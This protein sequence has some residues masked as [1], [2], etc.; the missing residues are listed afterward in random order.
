MT[1]SD[2]NYLRAV[3]TIYFPVQS[4]NPLQSEITRK[5]ES[6]VR[7]EF[8]S[9]AVLALVCRSALSGHTESSSAVERYIELG[10]RLWLNYNT[11][12]MF[13]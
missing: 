7:F 11:V 10:G 12:Q 9:A 13:W 5:E 8:V 1:R 6:T 4:L 2:L 3:A